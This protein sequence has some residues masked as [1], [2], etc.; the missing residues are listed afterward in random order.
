VDLGHDDLKMIKIHRVSDHKFKMLEFA[1]IP[2]DPDIPRESPQFHQF[3]KPISANFCGHQKNAEIWC[4]LS[5]ARVEIRQIRIPKINPRLIPTSVYWS[6]QRI[7][8]FNE[9]DILFDFEV[10]GDVEE[11]EKLKMEYEVGE[12]LEPGGFTIQSISPSRVV[13][14]P[15]GRKKNALILPILT[16]GLAA[17]VGFFALAIFLP[18]WDLTLMAK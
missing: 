1:R 11:E 10:L 14:A 13:I 3:L 5:S 8:P 6:Y 2:F 7:S 16:I 4:T 12:I 17:V 15:P 9:K 18:M